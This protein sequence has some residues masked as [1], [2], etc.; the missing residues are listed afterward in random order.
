MVRA[1]RGQ[2][3]CEG[4]GQWLRVKEVGTQLRGRRF[5]RRV[6]VRVSVSMRLRC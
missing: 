3:P 6:R 1:R 5:R 2:R 4:N